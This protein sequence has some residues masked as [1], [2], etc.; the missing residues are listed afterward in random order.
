LALSKAF[1]SDGIGIT[2]IGLGTSFNIELMRGLAEQADGNFYFVEDAAAVEEVFGQELEYFTMPVAFDLSLKVRAGRD[3]G[4][5]RS[6]G[7]RFFETNAENGSLEVP[8]VFLAHRQA[9]DDVTPD[10]GRRG[11][12]SALLVELMPKAT[13]EPEP[14]S[15]E[16]AIVDLE[17][18][19]PGTNRIVSDSVRVELPGSAWFLPEGGFFQNTI[20]EKSFV[21]LN[22]FVT[23]ESATALA[24]A[25]Q[26]EDAIAVLRRV[27][28]AAADYED[29]AHEGAG[30]ADVESDIALMEQ[31]I[32]VIRATGAPEPGQVEIPENPWPRD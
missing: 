13:Q 21:M 23:L 1:N 27:I 28:A 24:R 29:G 18:R 11:G 19:E 6:Y 8:S 31:L 7:S 30:D 17:F 4:L 5:L 16:V 26:G 9:H 14:A 22:V 3:F 32:D 15:S 12:G 20:V 25:G 10:G 2:S